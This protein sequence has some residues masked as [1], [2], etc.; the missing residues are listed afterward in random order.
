[1]PGINFVNRWSGALLGIVEA[2]LIII[3]TVNVMT[4]LPYESIQKLLAGS[5]VAPYLINDLPSLAGKL[6]ELWKQ[7]V[8]T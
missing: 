4:I 1:M 2:A 8:Q 3:I 5:A 7:G 6:Q